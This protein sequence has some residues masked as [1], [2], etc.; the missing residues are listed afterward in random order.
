MQVHSHLFAVAKAQNS[1]DHH[2]QHDHVKEE[3]QAENSHCSHL[4]HHVVAYI[5]SIKKGSIDVVS[6][7]KIKLEFWI[8]KVGDISFYRSTNILVSG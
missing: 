6:H 1:S 2:P 8:K 3:H 4:L 7:C 5:A